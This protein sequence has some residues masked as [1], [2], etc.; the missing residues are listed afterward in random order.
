MDMNFLVRMFGI[1]SNFLVVVM[2]ILSIFSIF[3]MVLGLEFYGMI[4][5]F[6]AFWWSVFVLIPC[7]RT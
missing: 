6:I 3:L 4:A 2:A 5:G 7:A 1:M